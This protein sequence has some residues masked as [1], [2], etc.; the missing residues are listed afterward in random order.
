MFSGYRGRLDRA[1]LGLNSCLRLLFLFFLL[2]VAGGPPLNN[3]LRL[4]R[5]FFL[6][7]FHLALQRRGQWGW[8]PLSLKFLLL[9]FLGLGL[10]LD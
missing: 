4:N 1:S 8:D 10:A 7:A 3:G 9:F 2:L 5:L 6:L